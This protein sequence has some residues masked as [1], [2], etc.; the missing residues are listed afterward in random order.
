VTPVAV[1]GGRVG[2]RDQ[3]Q[4]R[5]CVLVL[6]KRR[7]AAPKSQSNRRAPSS[8]VATFAVLLCPLSTCRVP[9]RRSRFFSWHLAFNCL[10]GV[11][12]GV[13]PQP[14]VCKKSMSK[15]N[16]KKS[17]TI[18]MSAFPRLFCVMSVMCQPSRVSVYFLKLKNT[19]KHLLFLMQEGHFESRSQN[20]SEQLKK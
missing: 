2:V 20:N 11:V 3:G 17:K 8:L 13:S 12:L 19:T 14:Y 15:K 10:L 7:E 18:P 5:A 9:I 1:A 6:G 4:K 16:Y